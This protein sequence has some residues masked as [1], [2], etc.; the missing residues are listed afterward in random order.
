MWRD[1]GCE[2]WSTFR[3]I[4]PNDRLWK[5]EGS[6]DFT[7]EIIVNAAE[8][9]YPRA[10]FSASG[11][12]LTHEDEELQEV[13]KILLTIK[14]PHEELRFT[15]NLLH[16]V[17]RPTDIWLLPFVQGAPDFNPSRFERRVVLFNAWQEPPLGVP[18]LMKEQ[19]DCRMEDVSVS[20]GN[21]WTEVDIAE[22]YGAGGDAQNC[23]KTWLLGALPRRKHAMRAVQLRSNEERLREALEQPTQPA[24]TIL[25][26]ASTS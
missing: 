11:P 10:A 2:V 5:A 23:A 25:P 3:F 24:R 13:D 8:N 20:P 15:G 9:C 7:T 12:K 16:A 4:K 18:Q 14:N 19:Q 6:S 26:A 22:G 17:P 21:E 1:L